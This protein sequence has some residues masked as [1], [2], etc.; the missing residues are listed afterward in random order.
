MIKGLRDMT[1][2]ELM[3]A[4]QVGKHYLQDLQEEMDGVQT[5]I[6]QIENELLRRKKVP[7]AET[8]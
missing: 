6:Y 8:R 2:Q 7:R 5:K 1:E 3:E 4:H